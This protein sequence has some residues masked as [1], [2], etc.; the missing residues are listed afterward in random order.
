MN[1]N[2]KEEYTIICGSLE[3]CTSKSKVKKHNKAMKKLSRLFHEIAAVEDK[4]FLID[5]LGD[6][7]PRT[8]LIVAAHCLGLKAYVPQAVVV[9]KELSRDTS[10]PFIS[11]EADAT[12]N[13]W[14]KTG[15]LSF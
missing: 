5:L 8:R 1:K 4:S 9:L 11:F 10:N 3:D 15:Y 14:K 6:S 12:L 2:Y 7:N 13:V